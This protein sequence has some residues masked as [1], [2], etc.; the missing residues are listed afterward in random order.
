[1][2]SSDIKARVSKTLDML[3]GQQDD[4]VFIK[5]LVIGTLG[6][7]EQPSSMHIPDL[8]KEYDFMVQEMGVDSQHIKA[9]MWLDG[10]VTYVNTFEK[11]D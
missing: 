1:M 10:F 6:A 9:K 4:P 8:V 7:A 3:G 11:V 2:D 5:G